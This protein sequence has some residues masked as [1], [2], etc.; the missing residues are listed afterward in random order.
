MT[1]IYELT[2]EEQDQAIAKAARTLALD[3]K[4]HP[5]FNGDHGPMFWQVNSYAAEIAYKNLVGGELAPETRCCWDVI[6]DE[7]ITI[8]VKWTPR[9]NGVLLIKD[10]DWSNAPDWFVLMIGLF[11]EYQYIGRIWARYL[12]NRPLNRDSKFKRPGHTASQRE[13]DSGLEF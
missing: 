8:D 5:F 7:R 4:G 6:V 3:L 10:K 2:K 13:L 9:K 12:I 11:P 1:R